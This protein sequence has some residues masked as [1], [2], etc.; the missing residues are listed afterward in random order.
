LTQAEEDEEPVLSMA[1]VEEIEDAPA[2]PLTVRSAPL[3]QQPVHL[4]ETNA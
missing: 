2:P 4:D 1:M 3:E